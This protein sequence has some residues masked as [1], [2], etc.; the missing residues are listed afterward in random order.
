MW[1][2]A[3]RVRAR[4]GMQ[5]S[6]RFATRPAI[7][8]ERHRGSNNTSVNRLRTGMGE[9]MPK[10]KPAEDIARKP[11]TH[12]DVKSIL[13]DLDESKLLPIMALR[14]TIADV[15]EASLWLGGDVD[16]FGAGPP[17]KGKASQIVTIL[18]AGEEEEE[19]PR[20]G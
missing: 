16:V 11:A 3:L 8:W 4:K 20:A 19:A 6:R 9:Q 2:V 18:T 5:R 10:P 15:E 17:L 13:G 7:R 14:P 1:L 12:D